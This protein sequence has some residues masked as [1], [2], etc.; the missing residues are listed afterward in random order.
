MG[1]HDIYKNPERNVMIDKVD[2][3]RQ[4]KEDY[5]TRGEHFAGGG[6]VGIR[7]PSAIPPESGPQSQGLAY[8]KKYGNDN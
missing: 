7:K 2:R 4:A 5:Y 1:N 8:L 3:L 6:M